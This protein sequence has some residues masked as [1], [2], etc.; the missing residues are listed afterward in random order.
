MDTDGDGLGNDTADQVCCC[1]CW[2]D[3]TN[4]SVY[5]PCRPG[6]LLKCA[7]RA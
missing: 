2:S 6:F 7:P 5:D 1:D 3:Q 4:A